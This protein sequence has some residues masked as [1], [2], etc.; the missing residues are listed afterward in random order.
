VRSIVVTVLALL[1]ATSAYAAGDHLEC[2]KI[3]DTAAR[4]TYVADLNGLTAEPGCVIKV[5]GQLLCVATTKTNVVP[6]PPGGGGTDPAGSFI[7]YKVKCPRSVLAPVTVQDQFG[8]RTVSPSPSRMLCAPVAPAT[9]STTT[10]TLPC[11]PAG[12]NCYGAGTPCCDAS[13]SCRIYGANAGVCFRETCQESADC[14]APSVCA[15]NQCCFQAGAYC[16]AGAPC[17]NG[18]GAHVQ[19]VCD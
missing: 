5:P 7:C 4:R 3:K 16:G 9:T 8:T 14:T 2:Y 18:C 13:L 12:D 17:C 10:T 11:V 19:D 6:T 15:G 1:V